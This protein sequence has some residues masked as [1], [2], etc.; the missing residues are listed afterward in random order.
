MEVAGRIALVAVLIFICGGMTMAENLTEA[1]KKVISV[2]VTWPPHSSDDPLDP[3]K[4]AL[5]C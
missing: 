1:E 3:G 5:I 2:M 4:E